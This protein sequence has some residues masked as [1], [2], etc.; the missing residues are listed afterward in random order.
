MRHLTAAEADRNK[1]LE[2]VITT[3]AE[4]N[5]KRKVKLQMLMKEV[6]SMASP[7]AK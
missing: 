3:E 2:Q 5:K 6:A 1:E 7:F 4:K